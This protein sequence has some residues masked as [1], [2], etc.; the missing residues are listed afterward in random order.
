MGNRDNNNNNNNSN[1]LSFKENNDCG[2]TARPVPSIVELYDPNKIST[3]ILSNDNNNKAT[4]K[5]LKF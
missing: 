1:N 3:G 4:E 5:R 2:M